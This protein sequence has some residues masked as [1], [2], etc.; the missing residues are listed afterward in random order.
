[1]PGIVDDQVVFLPHHLDQFFQLGQNIG[2]GGRLVEYRVDVFGL[3]LVF[4]D[5]ELDKIPRIFYRII[6]AEAMP[7]SINPDGQHNIL[8][9]RHGAFRR[10]ITR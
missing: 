7:V 1:M 9:S 3:K 6:Q 4:F 5:E 2:A 10:E 8:A